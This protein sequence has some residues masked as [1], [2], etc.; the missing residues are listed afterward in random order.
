MV[1]CTDADLTFA[2]ETR[3]DTGKASTVFPIGSKAFYAG[4]VT[5]PCATDIDFSNGSGCLV[6]GAALTYPSGSGWSSVCGGGG[7]GTVWTIPAKSSY[8][9]TWGLGNPK[10]PGTYELKGNFA[11]SSPGPITIYFDM[12]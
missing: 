6:K 12:K 1:K 7:G 2:L 10:E 11:G 9:E 4:I 5:N 3:D 8:E